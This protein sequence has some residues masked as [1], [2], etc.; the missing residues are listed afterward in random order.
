MRRIIKI[1]PNWYIQSQQSTL[2]SDSDKK[3]V[4]RE[5]KKMCTGYYGYTITKEEMKEC[6]IDH[7]CRLQSS[8]TW[9]YTDVK[10][11]FWVKISDAIRS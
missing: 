7:Y 10:Y 5:W 6:V 8:F 1:K 11:A 4:R 2:I 9:D 3:I